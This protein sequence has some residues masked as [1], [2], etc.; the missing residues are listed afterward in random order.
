MFSSCQWLCSFVNRFY[1]LAIVCSTDKFVSFL[2]LIKEVLLCKLSCVHVSYFSFQGAAVILPPILG[3]V[4][5]H[6]NFSV[7]VSYDVSYLWHWQWHRYQTVIVKTCELDNIH[8][9]LILTILDGMKLLPNMIHSHETRA[10]LF[11]GVIM[12]GCKRLQ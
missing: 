4:S 8:V 2:V 6:I 10:Q 7:K 3:C 9:I 12:N 1:M 11:T 5:P